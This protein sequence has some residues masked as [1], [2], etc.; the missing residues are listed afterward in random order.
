MSMHAPY[1]LRK[2]K[3]YREVSVVNDVNSILRRFVALKAF[4]VGVQ[5]ASEISLLQSKTSRCY[6]L[7]PR[8]N[9]KIPEVSSEV[10]LWAFLSEAWSKPCRFIY[11]DIRKKGMLSISVY[12]LSTY[13]PT[14]HND[15]A[16][17][18]RGSVIYIYILA[19]RQVLVSNNSTA[20]KSLKNMS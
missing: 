1:S 6:I 4:C 2:A 13:F 19:R 5:K 7:K 10:H 12:K 16:S 14:W 3:T 18:R 11:I 15:L 20:F 17:Y 9:Q 8:V